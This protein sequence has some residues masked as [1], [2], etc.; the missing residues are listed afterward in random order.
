MAKDHRLS[1]QAA[2]PG[3]RAGRCRLYLGNNGLQPDPDTES[4]SNKLNAM[5]NGGHIS[6]SW[7]E[8]RPKHQT[9]R[10]SEPKKGSTS[11]VKER[12][13]LIWKGK[14]ANHFSFSTAC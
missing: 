12:F 6:W 10:L 5:D 2:P 1:W 9:K 11:Y 8:N 3:P 13:F 4:D 14:R 7:P